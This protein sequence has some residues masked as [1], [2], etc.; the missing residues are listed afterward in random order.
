MLSRPAPHVGGST[1]DFYPS[2]TPHATPHVGGEH[3]GFRQ[4]PA[5]P[6]APPNPSVLP[7]I[8]GGSHG[9]EWLPPEHFVLPPTWGGALAATPHG[10]GYLC[11]SEA[12]GTENPE[13]GDLEM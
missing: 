11:T 9:G 5:T 12:G 3:F 8:V 4:T 2:A 6:H 7:P 10:G 1:F 13:S